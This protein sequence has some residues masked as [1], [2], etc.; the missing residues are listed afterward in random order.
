MQ[1]AALLS[2]NLPKEELVAIKLCMNHFCEPSLRVFHAK[3]VAKRTSILHCAMCS[4]GL[5]MF[6]SR[7]YESQQVNLPDTI[8]AASLRLAL[9]TVTRQ[10]VMLAESAKRSVDSQLYQNQKAALPS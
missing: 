2:Q 10:I 8:S 9:L 5:P 4:S 7:N 6:V 3:T 1:S